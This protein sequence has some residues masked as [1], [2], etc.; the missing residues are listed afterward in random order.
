MENKLLL[1]KYKKGR[2]WEK[3]PIVYAER[4]VKFLKDKK[5]NGM[6]V[7]FGCGNGRDVDVF[8]KNGFDSAGIDV[9]KDEI[10]LAQSNFPNCKFTVQNIENLNFK[11]NSIDSIFMINVIHYVNQEKTFDEISRVLK[12]GG[13]VFIHF[14]L[15]I[16]DKEDNLDYWQQEL[17]IL[18]LIVLFEIVHEKIFE[19]IDTQPKEHT[20]KIMELILRKYD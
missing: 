19:R 16:V 6:I 13:Y 5:F 7:D 3:H 2:H 1:D 14:N 17:E 4:F 15:E 18:N 12:P 11:D 8:I 20:H 10:K 9:S